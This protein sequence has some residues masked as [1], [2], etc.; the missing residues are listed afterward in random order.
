MSHGRECLRL[1]S[2]MAFPGATPQMSSRHTLARRTAAALSLLLA[3]CGGGGGDGGSTNPPP[4][5]R[6]PA[7]VTFEGSTTVTGTV[8]TAVAGAIAV[9]VRTADNLPVPRT[10]V[11]FSVSGGS[12]ASSTAQTDDNGRATAGTWTLGNTAG[13][14]TLTATAG[15]ANAT[16]TATAAAGNPASL[17]I[18]TP[19]PAT[20]R[21]GVA[22]TPAPSVR[23]KDQFNNVVNRG[24]L[25]ITAT[26]QS[27]TGVLAGATATTDASGLAT[28]TGLTLTGLVS[29]GPRT[30][31][32]GAPGIPS[33]NG[34][35][36]ALEAGLTAS[37]TLTNVPTN[38]RAGILV[39][40]GIT[41]R[42]RDQ[43]N[44]P[45]LRPTTVTASIASG[46]GTLQGATASTGT[47]GEATFVSLAIEG[48]VGARTLRFTADQQSV[49]TGAIALAPGDPAE[50][51]VTSQPTTIENTLPFASPVIVRV[52]DRFGNG[53]GGATRGVAAAIASG[54][55]TLFANTAQTDAVGVAS[56]DALRIVGS[57]GPRT[58]VFTS[59]GLAPVTTAPLQLEAGPARFLAFFQQPSSTV[60][61]SVPLLQ[62]PALQMADTSGNIVRRAGTV[63]R[64]TLLDAAGELL[65][66][67]ALTDNQGIAR[68]EQLTF[69]AAS[70]FPPPTL[71]LRFS[72]G[73]QATVVTA[74]LTIQN[75]PG[76]SVSS[77]Q[78]GSTSQ[79][80][81]VLDA[82]TSLTIAA[83]ARD[84]LNAPLPQVPIV[85]Q[86]IDPAVVSVRSN[87]S[88]TGLAGG[89]TWIRAFGAG[90]PNIK[91]SVY[92]TV[93]FDATAPVVR[94]TLIA[95]LPLR[96]NVTTGFDLVLDTRDA[97]IGA[98]TIVLSMPPEVVDGIS[99]QG[100]NGT[101]IGFDQA[102]NI[103]R[104]SAANA[105]GFRGIVTLA[106][107][108]ITA[109]AA[110]PF[111]TNR[112][113]IVTPL[114]VI[115]ATTLQNLASR[116]TG[117]NIPM[118]P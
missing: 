73:P 1:F 101:Q 51:R 21:A 91:D 117:V 65:N 3:A 83:T 4:P 72:A 16:L 11:T 106:S 45:I 18:V 6:V 54:G 88:I 7:S 39:A 17:E 114:E 29:D 10:T 107:I 81:F 111:L 90:N 116:S 84:A 42:I 78:Y 112:E 80:L 75:A 59:A 36:V 64:A 62:Q 13:T 26:L 82:G 97:T 61:V 38:A 37:L 56:F 43:F 77:L 87:G 74:G 25:A 24:G 85:Y 9:T 98:A 109:K 102:F 8:G 22:V 53:V 27:G 33:I 44:N 115:D 46:G 14:Q 34:T 113:L 118:I 66:D 5:T 19:L 50:L 104:I 55:G 20:L 41:A 86:P 71:R 79:K 12:I 30:I 40:P 93:P 100:A 48:Q 94:T 23:A 76:N 110:Q 57:A 28:F 63:V 52:T 2:C 103:L 47:T 31:A 105:A 95:P 108:T 58:L 92:V 70:N 32:F 60:T 35:P 15:S 69:L 99:W 96:A 89:S 67:V 68:F 49:T